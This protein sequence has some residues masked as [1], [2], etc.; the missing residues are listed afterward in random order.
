MDLLIKCDKEALG[1]FMGAGS[2][3]NGKAKA[4]GQWEAGSSS[5][6]QAEGPSLRVNGLGHALGSQALGHDKITNGGAR[7][8]HGP[9]GSGPTQV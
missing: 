5:T 2:K 4:L 1:P 9:T 3:T 7:I 8:E 6:S